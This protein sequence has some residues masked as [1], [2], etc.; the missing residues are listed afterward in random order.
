[1]T[2][3][4]QFSDLDKIYSTNIEEILHQSRYILDVSLCLLRIITQIKKF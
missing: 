4:L 3:V 1:M 2:I